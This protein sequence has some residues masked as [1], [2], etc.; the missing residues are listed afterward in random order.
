MRG[1]K[2]GV[3][4]PLFRL[5]LSVARNYRPE[6]KYQHAER[7]EEI[8]KPSQATG[9]QR[10]SRWLLDGASLPWPESLDQNV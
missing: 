8:G 3:K 10:Q 7:S 9:P 5:V 4:F 2:G 1:D 6:R